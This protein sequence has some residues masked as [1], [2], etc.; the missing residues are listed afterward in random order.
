MNDKMQQP[1]ESVNFAARQ[2]MA[3]VTSPTK[4]HQQPSVQNCDFCNIFHEMLFPVEPYFFSVV[5]YYLKPPVSNDNI[6]GMPGNM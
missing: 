5:K 6:S 1:T 3:L 4:T 2:G